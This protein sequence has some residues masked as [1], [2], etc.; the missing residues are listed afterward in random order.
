MRLGCGCRRLCDWFVAGE[1]QPLPANVLAARFILCGFDLRFDSHGR[2]AAA[3]WARFH[4]AATFPAAVP[5]DFCFPAL[6]FVLVFIALLLSLF[7]RQFLCQ[8]LTSRISMAMVDCGP[9]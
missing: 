3:P 6:M 7:L 8:L 9:D 2:Y 5:S 4:L 1:E